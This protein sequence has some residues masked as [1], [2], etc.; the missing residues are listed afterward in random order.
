MDPAAVRRY[1]GLR[2][3]KSDAVSSGFR[4]SGSVGTIETVENVTELLLSDLS[5]GSIENRQI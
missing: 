3:G 5:L 1:D 4:V 2:Y